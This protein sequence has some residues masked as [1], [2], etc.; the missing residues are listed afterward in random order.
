MMQGAFSE[1]GIEFAQRK[2]CTYFDPTMI[3][4]E[5]F[6][7]LKCQNLMLHIVIIGAHGKT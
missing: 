2:M 7:T 4:P 1:N 3:H 6:L 5:C